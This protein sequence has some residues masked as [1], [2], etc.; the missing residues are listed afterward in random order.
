MVDDAD[1]R[2]GL[3]SALVDYMRWDDSGPPVQLLLLARAAGTWWDRLVRQQE[4]VGA[5]TVLDLDRHPVPPVGRAEHFR[6]A[7]TAFAVYGGSGA[8]S[9]DVPLP[10][11]LEDPA[12]GDPLLI[13]IAALLRT[14][15]TSAIPPPPGPGEDR[16]RPK[17]SPQ[18]SR[19]C[20]S[21]RRCCG[22]CASGSGGP[23]VRLGPPLVQPGPAS[24]RSGGRAGNADRGGARCPPRNQAE[25][26]RIGAEALVVWAHRLYPGSGHWNPLRPDLLAEQHL[27]DTAQLTPSPP[28]PPSSPPASIGNPH[29]SPSCSPN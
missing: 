17:R 8:L 7:S 29:C 5:Y 14:V 28:P 19:A 15:D 24:G 1:L 2:T 13:H 6:R 27:A 3:V 10:T 4:L 9:A 12:Y 16:A 26:N 23:L 25:V 11:E 22:R 21:V 20:R 18:A